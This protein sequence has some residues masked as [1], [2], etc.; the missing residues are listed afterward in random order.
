[1][2]GEFIA[3]WADTWREI[4][5][6]LIEQEGVPDDVFCE[7]YR[8]L[9]LALKK[10][11]GSAAI[12]VAIDDAIQIREVFEK[13]LATA[14]VDVDAVR[15]DKIFESVVSLD[16][17]DTHKRRQSLEAALLAIVDDPIVATQ[18]L[19]EALG[20]IVADPSKRE[21][22]WRRKLAA[23]ANDKAKSKEAIQST[24]AS[25]LGGERSIV[26]FL[27]AAHSALEDLGGD[28][29][30]NHYFNLLTTFIEK[31][32]LRYDLRRP[33]Q[34]CPNLPGVFAGLFCELRKA[35][36]GDAHLDS[37]M[38]DFENAVRDLRADRSE[39]RI[40]S[41]IQK[42]VN[43][44]EALGRRC[45]GVTKDTLG[46]ICDEVGT[47]PHDGLM[48]AMKHVYRFTNKYPG[49]RHGGDPETVLRAVELRDFV[50]V[51]I[52]LSGFTPYL[53]HTVQSESAFMP[54]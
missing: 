1:M 30:S 38:K 35:T 45:P 11:T 44:I 12:E 10:P 4:W 16:S 34:L 53:A 51:T 46:R 48:E 37:L 43:L 3:V 27:E 7:L 18:A 54:Q 13:A 33:C 52:V 40:K 20:Q 47:W 21:E 50:A 14:G 23:I 29:L 41:C 2:R 22:A 49:I 19:S 42:Q 36:A 32:S 39:S 8:E 6:P 24:L 26:E 9:A 5:Q 28:D 17:S 15:R 25:D 31:F